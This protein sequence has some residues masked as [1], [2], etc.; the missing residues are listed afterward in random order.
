MLGLFFSGSFSSL[1][2]A[3]PLPVLGILL[4]FEAVTLM[5]MIRDVFNSKA[6]LIIVVLVGLAASQIPYGYLVGLVAGMFLHYAARYALE[7]AE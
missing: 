3:F 5:Q 4:L 1:A 2:Q 6:D 7:R